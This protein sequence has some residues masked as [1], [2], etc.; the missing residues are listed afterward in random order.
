MEGGGRGRGRGG[1]SRERRGRGSDS[2][3]HNDHGSRRK[4]GFSSE[5]DDYSSYKPSSGRHSASTK[6]T[7]TLGIKSKKPTSKAWK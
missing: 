7:S 6:L 3:E 4:G 5:D 2:D 1:K